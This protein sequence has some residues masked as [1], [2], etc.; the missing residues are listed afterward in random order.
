MKRSFDYTLF[1][2]V[3]LLVGFGLTMVYSSS[4]IL[5]KE[6][7]HQSAYFLKKEILYAVIGFIALFV[8]RKIP[9]QWYQKIV[10]P[11]FILSLLLLV[12]VFVPHLGQKVGGAHRWINLAVFSFQPSELSKLVLVI[13]LAYA[14]AKKKEKI[15]SFLIGFVPPMILSGLFISVVLL[16]KDLGNAFLMTAT[17]FILFFIAGARL[18][19]LTTEVLLAIPAFTLMIASVPY[20]R[21]RLLAFMNPWAHKNEAGFQLIQSLVAVQRGGFWGQGLGAGKQ[22]LFYLPE[23][24]TDFIFSV[25]AEEL[26]FLGVVIMLVLFGIFIYRT[27]VIAWKGPDLFATYLASGIGI[28]FGL[29]G[30]FNIG[31]V[32]GLVPTKGLTLPFVSYGGT[33]LVMSLM[34]V[35]ILLNISS[36]QQDPS[37]GRSRN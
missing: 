24:H 17:V 26:G 1:I 18:S 7:Y 27:F 20:R 5:A 30:L 9:Y 33:S 28:L 4:A 36:Q 10:Y 35:G 23:A 21:Q 32:M 29:Q 16:Q 34:A 8:T 25:V 19:Y 13:Y 2:A 11:L 22:K 6:K 3:V 15:R 12:A 31:V 37:E 14:L